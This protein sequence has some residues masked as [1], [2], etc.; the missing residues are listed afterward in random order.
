MSCLLDIIY[1]LADF[2]TVICFVYC[3]LIVNCVCSCFLVIFN[4]VV[5]T[6]LEIVKR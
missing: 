6:F 5:E 3:L 1:F 4:K 2:V